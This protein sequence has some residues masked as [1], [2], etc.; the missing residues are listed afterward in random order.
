MSAAPEGPELG[1][2]SDPPSRR[3][4]A[5]RDAYTALRDQQ[6]THVYGE[7]LGLAG[8]V[9]ITPPQLEYPVR[10]RDELVSSLLEAPPGSVHVA[11][12]GGRLRQIHGRA[13][14]G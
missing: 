14:R 9:S 7:Q 3:V 13:R 10:G 6:I 1:R 2:R 4:E 12:R 8:V 11:M 5:G